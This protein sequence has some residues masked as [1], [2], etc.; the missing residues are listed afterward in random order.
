[1]GAC[2][3]GPTSS[4]ISYNEIPIKA[5]KVSAHKNTIP[6]V[7][8]VFI[9]F[10]PLILIFILSFTIMNKIKLRIILMHNVS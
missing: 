8:L 5:V 10:T 7:S 3:L 9:K 2:P 4:P 6:L 1:M